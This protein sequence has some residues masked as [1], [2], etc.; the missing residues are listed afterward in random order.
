MATKKST[1][2]RAAARNETPHRETPKKEAA[3][4]APKTSAELKA[5]YL[6]DKAAHP[7]KTQEIFTQYQKDKIALRP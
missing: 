4:V 5:K 3:K 1:T 6:T 2:K 7:H